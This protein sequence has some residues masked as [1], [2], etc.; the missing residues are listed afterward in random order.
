VSGIEA[1]G[2]QM[3]DPVWCRVAVLRFRMRRPWRTLLGRL[4]CLR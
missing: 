2:E 4:A 3:L 1:E